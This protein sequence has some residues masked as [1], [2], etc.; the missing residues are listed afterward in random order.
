[1]PKVF[2]YGTGKRKCAVAKV[3]M[4]PGNGRVVVNNKD[5]KEYLKSDFLVWNVLKPLKKLSLEKKYDCKIDV[6]G[7]GLVVQSDASRLGV[8]RALLQFNIEF[9]SI[10][11]KEGF[12]T[13]DPRIKERKK[14][15]RK[16]ARKMPQYRKR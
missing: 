12:L 16:K 2:Y 8:A 3:R 11:K 4:F 5:I 6:K 15:G 14:Y 10:L 1:M 9:K 7:G 13:R